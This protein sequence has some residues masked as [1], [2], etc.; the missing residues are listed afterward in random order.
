MSLSLNSNF[1]GHFF[2]FD[3]DQTQNLE[4]RTELVINDK[5]IKFKKIFF[6]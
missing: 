6:N 2:E 1:D 4:I 5:R 3:Q